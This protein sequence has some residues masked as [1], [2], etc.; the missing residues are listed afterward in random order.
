MTIAVDF[1]GVVHRYSRGWHDGS[2]YDEPVEGA[3]EGLKSLMIE[4][5]VFILTSRDKWQ[6]ASW[7]REHGFHV[8]VDG[9]PSYVWDFWNQR[10]VLLVT[11]R[12][13]PATSYLDD[14]AVRFT[15]WPQALADLIG[16][17]A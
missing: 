14:R 13:L 6:V 8:T 4:E 15:S 16:K 9:P 12:K 10:G 5:A 11:N 3:L 17:E 2:I 1:D 7:L